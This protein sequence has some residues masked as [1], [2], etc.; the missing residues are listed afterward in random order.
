MGMGW[1]W[2]DGTGGEGGRGRR[3][4]GG[5]RGLGEST[6]CAGLSGVE[7]SSSRVSAPTLLVV[8]MV[9]VYYCSDEDEVPEPGWW[10]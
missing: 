2:A 10:R 5:E 1:G 4:G 6:V 3:G 7:P 8:Q 9:P